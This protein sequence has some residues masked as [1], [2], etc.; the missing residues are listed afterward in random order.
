MQWF[1]F[2]LPF[3][4]EELSAVA[5]AVAVI[6]ALWANRKTTLQMRDSLHAQEQTKNLEL[7][8]KRLA[9]IRAIELDQ[10]IL[11]VEIRL[12][13]DEQIVIQ[14][15]KLQELKNDLKGYEDD[16]QRYDFLLA[17]NSA[18]HG[19]NSPLQDIKDA[20]QAMVA[21]GYTEELVSYYKQLCKDNE[22]VGASATNP[23]TRVFNYQSILNN[24]EN[25]NHGVEMCKRQIIS[26]MSEYTSQSITLLKT[27]EGKR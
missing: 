5:T 16:L 13:F 22:V 24:I 1:D 20:Q 23:Q 3:G 10:L 14:F 11:E 26:Q 27:K 21:R 2:G 25:S 19:K 18:L 9:L 8:D 6:V 4:W 17:Y 15:R 12:L 7:F